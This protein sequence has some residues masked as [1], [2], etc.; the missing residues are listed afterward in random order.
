MV[1]VSAETDH[2]ELGQ[3]VVGVAMAEVAQVPRI[4]GM[5]PPVVVVVAS[6]PQV[7]F[8]Q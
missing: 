7:L 2:Q 4:I 8:S 5:T 6:V 3:A 1:A